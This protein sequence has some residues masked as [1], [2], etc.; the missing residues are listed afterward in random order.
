M[1]GI[2]ISFKKITIFWFVQSSHVVIYFMDIFNSQWLFKML[3]KSSKTPRGRILSL[4]DILQDWI[5]AP[6]IQLA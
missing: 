2:A 5:R 4:F 1:T 6:N 3:V